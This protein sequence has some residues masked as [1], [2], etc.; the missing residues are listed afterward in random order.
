M[1]F[2]TT[3]NDTTKSVEV[4]AEVKSNAAPVIS[5]Q[6]T[7]DEGNLQ[8]I[9]HNG[10]TTLAEKYNALWNPVKGK[11]MPVGYKGEN[12]DKTKIA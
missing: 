11:V 6:F 10:R 8:Y 2:T 7:D 1:Q 9:L 3:G 4:R 12:R 5:E